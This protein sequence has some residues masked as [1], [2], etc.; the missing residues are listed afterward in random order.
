MVAEEKQDYVAAYSEQSLWKKIKRFA[1]RAG[2]PLIEKV[3]I[4]YF[5]LQDPDTPAWAKV[6][7]T[8]ALGYF[9][10]PI[11]AIP[12]LV[13]IAGLTDDLGALAL[14]LAMVAA[15]IKPIH[16]EKAREKLR[17]WFG[18]N[19]EAEETDDDGNGDEPGPSGVTKPIP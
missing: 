11:D 9:I 14:A 7:I 6:T 17:I 10:V 3:L 18:E 15:H 2:R 1:K 16:V 12:D 13:P 4:L 5:C 19:E 8:G